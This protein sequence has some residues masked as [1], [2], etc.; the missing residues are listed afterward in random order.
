[1]STENSTPRPWKIDKWGTIRGPDCATIRVVGLALATGNVRDDDP[2]YANAALIVRAVN[3]H[4][5]LVRALD[6][7]ISAIDADEAIMQIDGEDSPLID[8]CRAALAKAKGG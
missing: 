6:A 7:V 5:A 1:M 3:A 2:A 8:E 4:D